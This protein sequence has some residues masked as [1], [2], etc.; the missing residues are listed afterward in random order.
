MLTQ[1]SA[2]QAQGTTTAEQK[3]AV[4]AIEPVQAAETIMRRYGARAISILAN[5]RVL[6]DGRR[7]PARLSANDCYVAMAEACR[8]MARVALRKYLSDPQLQTQDFAAAL[9]TIFPDPPAYLTRCLR[10]VVSDAERAARR[11]VPTLSIDQP[12]TTAGDSENALCL[13]DTLA[14]TETALQPEEALIAQDERIQFRKA[15][16]GAL[17]AIPKN[18][19]E[20]LHRD[21]ARERERQ[22]GVK[23]APESDRERQ[24]VCRARAALSEIL[25]RECGL[26]NPFV[27]LLSQQRSSRVRH[28]SPPSPNWTAERQNALFQRLMNTP[29]TERAAQSAHPEDNVEEAVVNEVSSASNIAP[30]SP[31]MRK[32]MRVMDAYVLGDNPT[33]Q[34]SEAQQLYQKAQ[35]AR[36][37][38]KLEEA[39]RLYRAAY[40]LEPNFFAAYNEAGVLLIQLG[41][42]RDALKI[43]LT[44]I[45]KTPNG[46][47][48]YIAATNAAD[49]YLTWFDAGRNRERN[50]ERATFYAR[51]AMEKPTP[52]R[53]CNLLLAYVKDRYYVEAQRVL[54][55]VLK[56]NRPECP[57]EKFLQTLFQIR[58]ADLV[59]WWNWLDAELG[60]DNVE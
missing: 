1:Q 25:R 14:T 34:T 33:A 26:D 43:F 8:K 47:D 51:L 41:N 46:D 54:D 7:L 42:L 4:C 38:G 11:D 37:A 52:M 40:E 60:K 19:L 15:L 2:R 44:I 6:E 20:A 3:A 5:P 59:A 36:Y 17:K 45:E 48:K 12:L 39:V 23:V 32:A 24:T 31:E 13:R 22:A 16:S 28:K 57:P 21:I 27:R 55:T 49:I 10:S 58:D 50:I 9:D 29:W 53:A 56:A 30:P 18:Y 35:E